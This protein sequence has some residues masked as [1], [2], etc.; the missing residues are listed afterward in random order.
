MS[1]YM[2]VPGCKSVLITVFHNI[3][4]MKYS[5]PTRNSR[6]RK[7]RRGSRAWVA[8]LQITHN[9]ASCHRMSSIWM[10]LR[11][12]TAPKAFGLCV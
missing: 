2:Y 6:A 10:R 1:C 7:P 5:N 4:R 9:L 8:P 3:R 12:C 11:T